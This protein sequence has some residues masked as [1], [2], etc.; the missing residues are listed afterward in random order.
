[1]SLILSSVAVAEALPLLFSHLFPPGSWVAF[2][3]S[4]VAVAIVGEIIPLAIIP[5]YVL[6]FA[7]RMM[8]FVN[9]LMW[10][11]AVPACMFAYPLRVFKRWQK[12]RFP[13]RMD[14][15]LGLEELVEFVRL[16]EKGE[17]FGGTL[18]D[19]AGCIVR[20]MMVQHEEIKHW[21]SAVV[22]YAGDQAT[23]NTFHRR[24]TTISGMER[25]D[26]LSPL[27]GSTGGSSN[28]TT[29][30]L[31]RRTN[32]S[33]EA[34]S[35]NVSNAVE[36]RSTREDVSLG[37]VMENSLGQHE[38]RPL[39]AVLPNKASR[40]SSLPKVHS[41]LGQAEGSSLSQGDALSFCQM[42][43]RLSLRQKQR[44]IS[45]PWVQDLVNDMK[46]IQYKHCEI[47]PLSQSCQSFIQGRVP[48]NSRSAST[49]T[50]EIPLQPGSKIQSNFWTSG[51][52]PHTRQSVYSYFNVERSRMHGVTKTD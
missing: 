31:R 27:T 5:M 1:M 50:I 13:Y 17:G 4:T 21:D 10:L 32:R 47:P 39:D 24:S 41:T 44:S 28:G 40:M 22:L 33:S 46:K 51:H 49:G 48:N 2:G 37:K 23:S 9:G 19:G 26:I 6:E 35:E 18:E 36:P 29:R 43:D 14:G 30:G 45:S 25:A 12:S 11:M 38:D 42:A 15:I 3:F 20:M 34:F 52:M 16:H 7:G 8:W